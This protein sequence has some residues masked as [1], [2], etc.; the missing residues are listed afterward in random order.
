MIEKF[1]TAFKRL[2]RDY[3]FGG[4]PHKPILLLS[5]L[6][7]VR[8]NEIRDNRIFI[9]PELI[10]CFR[11][12]WTMLVSTPHK[13]NFSLPFFHMRSEP[14]WKL[15][16]KHG[17]EIAMTK[18]NS[19]KSLTALNAALEYATIDP[20]LFELMLDP[21]ANDILRQVIIKK[22]FPGSGNVRP[23]Y[24]GL[25][26]MQAELFMD[27][28]IKY[29]NKIDAIQSTLPEDQVEEELFVRGALF[30]RE[31]PK[32]YNYTCAATKTKVVTDT[33]VQMVDAC[34]IVPFSIS[35]DDTVRNGISFSP[36][37]HRA[38]DRGII[39]LSDDFKIK[40]SSR[41]KTDDSPYS[42]KRLEGVEIDLPVN[43]D[44]HPLLSN[45]QWHRKEVWLS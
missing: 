31:I 21:V 39:T 18:S 3:S 37:I 25:E 32:L 19:V 2:R 6:D 44:Y 36:T 35:K 26:V 45:L 40:V 33:D 27:D 16:T 10:C 24:S 23:S 8:I 42:I 13:I 11:E 4:A 12:Y 30:K 5:I 7:G 14:F 29:R 28:S 22:Y 20:D 34:H 9:T 38:F 17:L 15:V 1:V 43:V 41:I